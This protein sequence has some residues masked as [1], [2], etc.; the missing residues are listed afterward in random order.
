MDITLHAPLVVI[1]YRT[2]VTVGEIYIDLGCFQVTNMFCH[3]SELLS[4]S[5]MDTMNI[6]AG[7]ATIEKIK[8]Q[9]TSIEIFR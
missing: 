8:I 7:K 2:R 3:G 1:P 4:R 9:S 6:K 5:C